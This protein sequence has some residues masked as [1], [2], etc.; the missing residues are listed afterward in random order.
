MN[1][2]QIY[3]GLLNRGYSAPQAAA[4]TGNILQESGGDPTNVN[5]KEG[6]HGLLQWRQSR[7]Q[8]LLDYANGRGTSPDD[9][10]TQ[11]DYIGVEMGGPEKRSAAG[12]QGANDVQSANSALKGYIRYGDN[13]QGTRLAYAQQF[14]PQG[15]ATPAPMSM[16]GPQQPAQSAPQQAA[17][18]QPKPQNNAQPAAAPAP[19]AAP[20]PTLTP[21]QIAQ[22]A[23]VP[24]A[25]NILPARPNPYAMARAPFSLGG[26]G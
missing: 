22:L 23:A 14:L 6:A 18:E 1:G 13:S 3:H 15:T 7:Y 20:T 25:P 11:L 26:I 21:D 9:P 17:P 24:Q 10:N 5:A 12:F 8:G 19:A 2:D 4:L 16:A